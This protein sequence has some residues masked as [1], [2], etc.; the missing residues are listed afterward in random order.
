MHYG[1]SIIDKDTGEIKE[2]QFFVAILG[3]SQTPMQ[4]LP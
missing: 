2:V 4:K 3:A 1:F